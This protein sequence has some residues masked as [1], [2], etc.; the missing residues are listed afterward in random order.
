MDG[1]YSS[2]ECLRHI[3]KWLRIMG[4]VAAPIS[5]RHATF[6]A[7]SFANQDLRTLRKAI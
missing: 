6:E 2:E 3:G 4:V 7:S 5:G 1:N